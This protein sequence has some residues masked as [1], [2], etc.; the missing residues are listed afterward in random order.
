[1]QPERTASRNSVLS[2][3]TSGHHVDACS[4]PVLTIGHC[5]PISHR[6]KPADLEWN[7]KLKLALFWI[8][9]I[10][11]TQQLAVYTVALFKPSVHFGLNTN[12]VV[13]FA[14]VIVQGF[15]EGELTVFTNCHIQLSLLNNSTDYSNQRKFNRQPY[16]QIKSA[17][18]QT[19]LWGL[20]LQWVVC[21][22]STLLILRWMYCTRGI[23][24]LSPNVKYKR[25][26][27]QPL[28]FR[29][30]LMIITRNIPLDTAFN[31][32]FINI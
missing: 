26:W 14:N 21:C 16:R 3:R 19:N 6:R 32:V 4:D 7:L 30:V 17:V 22:I 24:T 8:W 29:K 10:W 18:Y 23:L 5:T 20:I 12:L 15:L 2:D 31:F 11:Y 25:G 28:V 1:M 27:L 9:L 13:S